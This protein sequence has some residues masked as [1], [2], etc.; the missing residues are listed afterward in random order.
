[1]AELHPVDTAVFSEQGEAPDSWTWH[2]LWSPKHTCTHMST[3]LD[4][5]HTDTMPQ[6]RSQSCVNSAEVR[7]TSARQ[8]ASLL[9]AVGKT[10]TCGTKST[11]Q[12]TACRGPCVLASALASNLLTSPTTF[13]MPRLHSVVVSSVW[14]A[15]LLLPISPG[16]W[17]NALPLSRQLQYLPVFQGPSRTFQHHPPPELTILLCACTERTST[18]TSQTSTWV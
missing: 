12:C 1:M 16:Q 9:G 14:N 8:K 7:C 11:L 17:A 6:C 10:T 5:G 18:K 15:C 3:S 4:S 13:L 2:P